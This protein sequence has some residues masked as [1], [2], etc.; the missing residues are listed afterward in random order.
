MNVDL[1]KTKPGLPHRHF[2]AFESIINAFLSCLQNIW[3]DVKLHKRQ[4]YLLEVMASD[5]HQL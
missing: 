1:G 4:D 5:K 3:E 2:H